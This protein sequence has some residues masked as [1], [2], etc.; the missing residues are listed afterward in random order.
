MKK[1]DGAT[2]LNH[3]KFLVP[4]IVGVAAAVILAIMFLPAY[5]APK[6][7]DPA[8][9]KELSRLASLTA[10]EEIKV[11]DLN[12]LKA[13]LEHDEGA[14]HELDEIEDFVSYGEYRHAAHS[15]AFLASY[16]ETGLE[17]ICPGHDLA[18]YYV[19]ARHGNLE[20]ANH[21]LESAKETFDI[22]KHDA[23]EFYEKYPGDLPFDYIADKVKSHILAIEAGQK[24]T[25]EEEIGFLADK[26]VCIQSDTKHPETHGNKDE[27]MNEGVT[28]TGVAEGQ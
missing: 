4:I 8:V 5:E 25:T 17:T 12:Q 13:M 1:K 3:T 22:W 23:R 6:K 27:E 24:N 18:H 15:F 16:L 7:M 14:K 9:A 10:K 28:E 11:S 2:G 19:Y 21:K 20:E 26:T